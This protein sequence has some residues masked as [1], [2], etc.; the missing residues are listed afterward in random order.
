MSITATSFFAIAYILFSF[1]IRVKNGIV[2]LFKMIKQLIITKDWQQF[3]ETFTQR[4]PKISEVIS[5]VK[6]NLSKFFSFMKEQGAPFVKRALAALM[7]IITV[8]LTIKTILSFNKVLGESNSL[9]SP[10]SKTKILSEFNTVLILCAIVN[11]VLS[12][13]R[14]LIAF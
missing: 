1:I 7:S 14:F 6:E 9:T 5:N 10:L 2:D 12:Y 11:I 3:I 8:L 4:F 13:K